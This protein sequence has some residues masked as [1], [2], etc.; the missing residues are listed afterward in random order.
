METNKEWTQLSPMEKRDERFAR[1]LSPAD[2]TFPSPEV[3]KAYEERV[4]RFVRVIKL[5]EEPDRVPVIVPA[6]FFPAPYAG[7]TF[8][9]VMYD[10]D[11]MYDAWIKFL[12]EFELDSF[13]SPGFVWPGKMFEMLDYKLLQW[14]GHGLADDIPSYQY[15]EGEYMFVDEYDALINN[16]FDYLVR[17]WLPRTVGA[18]GGFGKLGEM[19]LLEYL[20]VFYIAQFA[21]PEVRAS[22]QALLD[23][24][25][26]AAEWVK[27][28]GKISRE[29]TEYGVPSLVG[30]RSRA[31]FDFLGDSLRGTKGAMLDMYKRPEKLLEAMD[32]VTPIIIDRTVRSM[33]NA[34]SPVVVFTLHKGPGGFMSNKQFG[35]FY[36]PSLRR[37]MMGLVE[38]GL[39]PMCFAEGDYMPRLDVIKEMPRGTTIWHFETVDMAAAKSIVGKDACIAGNLPSSILCTGT[40]DLVKE[41]CRQLIETCAPGGGYILTGGAGID[42]GD[43]ENLRAMTAAAKEY[44]VYQK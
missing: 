27:T 40:P 36:W 39:V 2:I 42:T 8:K 18:F 26:Q 21:D 25:E 31:P 33:A 38:Q 15:V 13:A 20:P 3:R 4:G 41:R 35:K 7:M 16:P 43:P 11:K 14:P 24:A 37:V 34:K 6:G 19:P 5:E 30:G 23:A 44:G 1:W 22:V 10:C 28:L 32:V 29:A 9:T 17:T 12:H